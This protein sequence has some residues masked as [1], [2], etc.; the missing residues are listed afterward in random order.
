MHLLLIVYIV[1]SCRRNIIICYRF[2]TEMD[3]Y[4]NIY[5]I[6]LIAAAAMVMMTSYS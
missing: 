4:T 2:Y 5:C 6:W 1:Q 3:V